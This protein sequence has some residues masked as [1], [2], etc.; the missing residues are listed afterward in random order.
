MDWVTRLHQFIAGILPAS[1][2]A[3]WDVHLSLS[4]DFKTMVRID[5]T[6]PRATAENV[7]LAHHPRFWWHAKLAIDG[8]DLLD[9]LFDATGIARSFPLQM[10]IW[11]DESFALAVKRELDDAAKRPVIL[12]LLTVQRF[13]DFLGKSVDLRCEPASL[14]QS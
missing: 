12:D 6:I 2:N 7:L 3:E 5:A 9:L 8:K 1:A 10:A 4:N 11:R 13:L 14:I